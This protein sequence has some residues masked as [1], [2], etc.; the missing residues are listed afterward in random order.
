MLISGIYAFTNISVLNV[1]NEVNTGAVKISLNEYTV[2]N[3]NESLYNQSEDIVF[4][5]QIISLI[6]RISNLGDSSYIRAKIGYLSED[7]EIKLSD[8]NIEGMSDAWI[9]KGDY[10]YYK[11]IVNS[12]EN[13]DIFKSF[14]I[15]VDISNEYQGRTID[16][17]ITAEAVQASNFTP[18][19]ESESP[20]HGI[21]AESAGEYQL[22]KIQRNINAVIEYENNA[23]FYLS[24]SDN[25]FGTLR[26]IVPG[27][28]MSEE[29][30]I[31]N[32]TDNTVEYYVS[33]EGLEGANEKQVELL[34][35]LNLRI[36]SEKGILYEGSLLGLNQVDLGKYEANEMSKIKFTVTMP[37]ELGNEYAALSSSIKWKFGV[38]YEDK[39]VPKKE[40]PKVPSP[41]TGD[42]KIKI[43]IGIFV[44]AAIGLV[45]A[46]VLEKKNK[47][48]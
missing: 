41:Q 33:T 29:V 14:E 47:N 1:T 3:G 18:N 42:V 5:G 16:L 13:V 48:K 15:P 8:A 23:N 36:V 40:E 43:A 45:V 22:D 21:N 35:K 4:P 6:P 2:E 34:K 20:W 46:L 17:N 7:A 10:W 27:D 44:I 24:V 19:F 26:H 37:A 9:K 31:N 32:K 39:V 12:G 28:S 30:S 11:N 38:K 25:F